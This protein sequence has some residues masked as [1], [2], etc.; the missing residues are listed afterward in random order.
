M[1]NAPATK[2]STIHEI[3]N[4]AL[5]ITEKLNLRRTTLAFD[6]ALYAKEV[7]ILWNDGKFKLIVIRMEVF[8][9]LCNLMS[10]ISKRFKDASS[11][12]FKYDIRGD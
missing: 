1:L 10:I 4:K 7:E 11:I 6:Q 2:M 12:E 3:P 5:K 9:R 8:H